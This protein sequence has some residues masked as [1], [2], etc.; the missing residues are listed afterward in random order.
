MLKVCWLGLPAGL[1]FVQRPGGY[2]SRL[3]DSKEVSH[4]IKCQ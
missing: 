4:G 2:R 3:A 1:L